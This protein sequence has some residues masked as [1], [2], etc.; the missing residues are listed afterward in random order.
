MVTASIVTYNTPANEL[1]KCLSSLLCS[2]VFRVFIS[3][4]SPNDDLRR[5][6]KQYDCVEY[7]FNNAN[8]GYG[9]GHNV[10]IRLAMKIPS[11]YHIVLNSDVHF[12]PEIIGKITEFMEINENVAQLQPKILYPDG[13]L[14]LTQRLLPTPLN[15]I[16]RR[17]LPKS[18][19]KILNSK[20]T[21]SFW[22]HN[23]TANIP[24]HQGSFMFFRMDALKKVGLF[25]ERFFMYP[26]DIDI[27]RRMY[28]HFQTIYWPNVSIV[29]NHR[30]ESYQSTKLLLIHIINMIKY[31]NKW[32]WIVDK[33][34]SIW[35]KQ[36]LHQLG[37]KTNH[38]T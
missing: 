36:V 35:N 19:S 11:R 9:A 18:L 7:I 4:N 31:F 16:S 37:Y 33:E 23:C 25:D 27:T 15:L 22:D 17:F 21:L 34:R 13:T 10:A 1:D 3:D 32:G 6:C 8:I 12:E 26:E 30:A 29:H 5:L 14:Q 38:Q 28:K 2:P 24:Y 20:Y